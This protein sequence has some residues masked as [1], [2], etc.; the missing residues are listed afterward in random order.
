MHVYVRLSCLTTKPRFQ[1][2]IARRIKPVNFQSSVNRKHSH[3]TY[4]KDLTRWRMI[5]PG[6]MLDCDVSMHK[7][8]S[9]IGKRY[10]CSLFFSTPLESWSDLWVLHCLRSTRIFLKLSPAWPPFEHWETKW[11]S[12]WKMN[13]DWKPTSGQISAVRVFCSFFCL[14]KFSPVEISLLFRNARN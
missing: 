13:F 9:L 8:H 6:K 14:E 5:L 1:R 3:V 12:N 2:L 4:V 7:A 11:D 10:L